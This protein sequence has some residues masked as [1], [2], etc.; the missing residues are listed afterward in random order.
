MNNK[1]I[2][3]IIGALLKIVD[4][5]N[6]MNLF[7]DKYIIFVKIILTILTVY[8]IN[9]DYNYSMDMVITCIVCYLIKQI[10]T[11]YYKIGTLIIIL[12]FLYKLKYYEFTF[13]L[14]ID[15]IITFI[16]LFIGAYIENNL[17]KEE[18]SQ[19]KLY[20]RISGFLITILYVYI[21]T[22]HKKILYD[23]NISKNRIIKILY[24]EIDAILI[25]LGYVSVSILDISYMLTNN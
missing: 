2:S 14:F 4:D 9:I 19:I 11:P 5:N 1:I 24:P 6:D 18:Y 3:F 22:F 17:F 10:D 25:V 8:W 13:D 12:N 21:F 15:K 23:N 20:A 16:V 7:N